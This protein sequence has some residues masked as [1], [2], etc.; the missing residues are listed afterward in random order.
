MNWRIP[1]FVL[2]V[3]GVLWGSMTFAAVGDGTPFQRAAL[4]AL[5]C[6]TASV[7]FAYLVIVLLFWAMDGGKKK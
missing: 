1:V 6:L 7:I 5:G 2:I 3:A 4:Y